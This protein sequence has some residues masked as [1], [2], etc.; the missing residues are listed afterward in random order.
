MSLEFELHIR[1]IDKHGSLV[2]RYMVQHVLLRSS[3]DEKL[4]K[5]GREHKLFPWVAIA[6]PLKVS[7]CS[8]LALH[9]PC[10]SA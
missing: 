5:W 2:N 8:A 10:D 7:P 4:D 9:P 3:D 1:H 6:A